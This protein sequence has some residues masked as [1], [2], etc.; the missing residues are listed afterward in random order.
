MP[1]IPI[2]EKSPHL[3]GAIAD[4]SGTQ[5]QREKSMSIERYHA[6]VI[7]LDPRGIDLAKAA[8]R[9]FERVAVVVPEQHSGCPEGGADAPWWNVFGDDQALGTL[10]RC[11]QRACVVRETVASLKRWAGAC[12]RDAPAGSRSYREAA[13]HEASRLLA[14]VSAR[15]LSGLLAELCADGIDVLFGRAEFEDSQSL[16][17]AGAHGVRRVVADAFTLAV[18]AQTAWPRWVESELRG[19]GV[20]TCEAFLEE[21]AAGTSADGGDDAIAGIVSVTAEPQSAAAV[22]RGGCNGDAVDSEK[23]NG[24]SAARVPT[25]GLQD[26]ETAVV[27]GA[28]IRGLEQ[29][30]LLRLLGLRVTVIDRDEDRIAPVTHEILS[31]AVRAIEASEHPPARRPPAETER[32]AR[33][34]LKQLAQA[35]GVHFVCDDVLGVEAAWSQSTGARPLRLVCRHGRIRW[36]EIVVCCGPQVGRTPAL[37]LDRIGLLTDEN[38]RVWCDCRGRTWVDGVWAV[39]EVVGFRTSREWQV[40]RVRRIDQSSSTNAAHIS[41]GSGARKDSVTSVIGCEKTS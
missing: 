34:T 14:M 19:N 26:A 10:L 13:L 7:G 4:G 25:G 12:D 9:R 2:P 40:A 1:R 16:L 23:G 27:V 15:R 30:L 17:V 21:L 39:G 3:S 35:A 24:G 22:C 36:G 32:L 8:A 20:W 29:A 6:V 5:T 38:D 31:R 41:A 33:L 28:G 18:G 37:R 11:G